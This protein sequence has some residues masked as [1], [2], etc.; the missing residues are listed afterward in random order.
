MLSW[1]L[2]C[3]LDYHKK[4]KFKSTV[5]I[6]KSKNQRGE[7]RDYRISVEAQENFRLLTS[8]SNLPFE[9]TEFSIKMGVFPA[10]SST[11]LF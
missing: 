10:S 8:E 4:E 9:S 5:D 3:D 6:T 7:C 2:P 11:S 1:F